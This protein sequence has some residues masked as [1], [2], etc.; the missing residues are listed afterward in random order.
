[1]H[2][3]RWGGHYLAVVLL[4]CS[5]SA[6]E[7]DEPRVVPG[8]EAARVNPAAPR[9]DGDLRDEAWHHLGRN[10]VRDFTQREPDEGASPTESTQVAVLYDDDALYFAFWCYDSEPEKIARQLVRRDRHAESDL[11]AVRLDPYHDHQTGYDLYLSA[12]GVQ[13]DG[14]LSNDN[15]IDYAWDGVWESGVKMQPWGWSA[16]MRIPF[17]CL[18]FNEEENHTWGIDFAR[19]IKRKAES[20][21]W[22]F[23]PRAQGGYVSNFGHLTGLTGIKPRRLI[24]ILPYGVSSL[25]TE[26]ESRGNPDGREHRSNMGVDMKYGLAS[27][28][29]LDAT[30]NPDFGQVE[31]DQPV[32]NLS[33]FETYF[34]ERR[35]FFLEGADLYDS[36]F[37]LFY[38]RRIG[39]APGSGVQDDE[40]DYY[41]SYPKATTILGAAKLTGRVADRTSI[42]CLTAMTEGEK[43]EYKTNA[44]ETRE[45]I[46]EPEATYSVARIKQDV[47]KQSSVGGILTLAAQDT[48]HPAT[49][50]GFD[51]RLQTNNN[52]WGFRGQTIFSRVDAEKT[53][54]G[55]DMTFGKQAG[56]HVEWAF[57]TLIKDPNLDI[58]DLGYTSRADWRGTWVWWQYKTSDDIWIVRN[59]WNNLNV[60]RAWN[61]AG[62]NIQG[63]WN[64]NNTIEFVNNWTGGMGFNRN[65]P[66]VN[67]R[68]TRGHGLWDTPASW[69][70]WVWLDTDERK[71]FSVE[72][73]YSLGHSRTSPWWETELLFRYRPVANAA[74]EV[75]GEF[76]HDFDQLS[77][78]T[79]PDEETT[80]FAYRDQDIFT[81]D[82]S[83]DWVFHRDLSCQLSARG[84]LT[85]LD[86]HDYR[87]YLGG[88]RYGDAVG[89]YD[90][91]YLYSALNSTFLLRWEY[92]PGS[93]LYAVWTRALSDADGSVNQLDVGRDID[94]W[95]NGDSE[96]LFLVKVSYRLAL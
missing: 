64:F 11:I 47:L 39:R 4:A 68:E 54:F 30:I 73:D 22:A 94:R 87:P 45:G 70:A 34:S 15:N 26:P 40:L 55:L 51:W 76:T 85:S 19:A 49:T 12:A 33:T 6:A 71:P 37:T 5:A 21:R 20:F 69:N 10:V 56:E 88:G 96:N 52:M 27:N 1:M 80:I 41:T 72:L 86:H 35:P 16:E 59:S 18:R 89:G 8:V 13:I 32:L 43:A 24:E 23:V 36:E 63:N 95:F 9:I 79:N 58:N 38:S 74:F 50:G 75:H 60:S 66:K 28:L 83:A 3:S 46:V 48:R 44:G 78:V 81:L 67:D 25:E 84:L 2:G 82:A 61:Y 29:I 7:A 57:G 77:W 91:D 62:D 90:A 92:R 65:D 93:T 31:L 14:R 53:G 42:A 17:Q